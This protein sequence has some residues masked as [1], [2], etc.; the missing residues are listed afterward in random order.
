MPRIN[1]HK[2][3]FEN[4]NYKLTYYR[5]DKP[6]IY[7][8]KNLFI[9]NKT[10]LLKKYILHIGLNLNLNNLTPQ[11]LS[12]IILNHFSKEKATNGLI[13][14]EEYNLEKIKIDSK[15]N[16][17]GKEKKDDEIA[18]DSRIK[19]LKSTLNWKKINDKKIAKL[20][21]IS[22][23]DTKKSGG[24][25][26]KYKNYNF[27]NIFDEKRTES[28]KLY[29]KKLIEKP[30]TFIFKDNKKPIEREKIPVDENYFKDC[31]K[32][33]KYKIAI[34]RYAGGKFY[35]DEHLK[36]YKDKTKD[37]NLKILIVSALF[38]L[39]EFNDC[40]PDYHLKMNDN[41]TWKNN[42]C[43]KKTVK[44]YIKK[45]NIDDVYY[46]LAP[47]T[48]YKDCL[49]PDNNWIDL[50]FYLSGS[51]SATQSAKYLSTHFLPQL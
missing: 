47:S 17:S 21:I 5:N 12:D 40:I 2:F 23:S 34:E 16:S 9:G 50:W 6:I 44:E 10:A 28:F 3:I 13:N 4:I 20:L 24:D 43:L 38:G 45:H 11:K 8:N 41:K 36:L 15:S 32:Q 37:S 22:C 7:I 25:N 26:S 46:S 39:L 1:E 29:E 14:I 48:G 18:T 49:N 19:H 33:K 42:N 51:N 27:G 35:K 31:W 30:T